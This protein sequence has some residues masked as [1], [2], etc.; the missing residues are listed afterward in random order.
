MSGYPTRYETLDSLA[1]GKGRQWS[2][3]V[4]KTVHF[5]YLRL[6]RKEQGLFAVGWPLDSGY[7][8]DGRTFTVLPADAWVRVFDP[9]CVPKARVAV[10][11]L[12]VA[13]FVASAKFLLQVTS[14]ARPFDES[15]AADA[16]GLGLAEAGND[17]DVADA[18]ER[19][20]VPMLHGP[21]EEFA[22]YARAAIGLQSITMLGLTATALRTG[23]T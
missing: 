9:I 13:T 21:E 18:T 17:P 15:I 1:L 5:A 14:R 16:S 7:E 12:V 2:S 11:A 19:I 4:A 10:H 8:G 3:H 23:T 22:V 20:H 6:R